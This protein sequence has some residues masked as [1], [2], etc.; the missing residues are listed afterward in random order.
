M[1]K[2]ELLVV[3]VT[4]DHKLTSFLKN[5]WNDARSYLFAIKFSL[6]YNG[7]NLMNKANFTEAKEINTW[8]H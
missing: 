6:C 3:I 7:D 2:M 1:S 5:E 8:H 4:E